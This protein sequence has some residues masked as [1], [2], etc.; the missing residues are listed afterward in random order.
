VG[1]GMGSAHPPRI[2]TFRYDPP[3]ATARL[4]FVGKGITFDSGGLCLKPPTSMIAMKNDMA[5]AA[6]VVAAGQAIADLGLPVAVSG[7]LCVAEN[8]PSGTAQRPGDVVRMRDGQTVEVINTDAEGRLVLADGLC[9]ASETQ[10]DFIVDVATLTGAAI[11][12]LGRR[13]AAVL[14]NDDEVQAQVCQAATQAGESVW[15]MPIVEEIRPD[16][17]STVA[18]LKH[19]GDSVGGCMIGAA[20]LREFV[21]ATDDDEPIPWAHVDIAGPSYNDS[22]PYGYTPKGATGF[23]VRTLVALAEEVARAGV[24]G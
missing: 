22:K 24:I 15:P 6:A 10:P 18:D 1:V 5:G 23:G 2:V 12:A 4:A 14:A 7:W 8:M 16:L 19:T 3:R 13:T 21:G 20:F 17:K 9:L 11:I